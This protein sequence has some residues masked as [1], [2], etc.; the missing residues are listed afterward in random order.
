MSG[1]SPESAWLHSSAAQVLNSSPA[2]QVSQKLLSPAS[3][4]LSPVEDSES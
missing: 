1:V 3:G 4:V 2:F